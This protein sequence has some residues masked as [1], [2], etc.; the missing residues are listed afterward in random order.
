MPRIQRL[1]SHVHDHSKGR[2][3]KRPQLG[4]TGRFERALTRCMNL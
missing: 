1:D 3:G 4:M 2:L